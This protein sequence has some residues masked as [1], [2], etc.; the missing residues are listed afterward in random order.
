VTALF[1]RLAVALVRAWTAFY[2]WGMAP[3]VRQA[4]RAEIDSDLW[5][6]QQGE[7]S[8]A[9][10]PLQIIA[11][12]VLGIPDD[13]GWRRDHRRAPGRAAQMAWALAVAMTVLVIL[14]L[15]WIGRAQPLPVPV[16]LVRAG[17]RQAL[18][19]PPP[20]PPCTPP[21]AGRPAITP[22]TQY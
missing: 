6:C 10:L 14:T 5:D 11:R 19:P 21:A 8:G 15:V 7:P 18:P 12:L 9:R 20:P 1:V 3:E 2:T 16:P 4:R 22:C 13:L 17:E